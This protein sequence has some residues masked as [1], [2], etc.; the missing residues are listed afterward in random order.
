MINVSSL[1]SEQGQF[2]LISHFAGL[3]GLNYEL[4]L[5]AIKSIN[6]EIYFQEA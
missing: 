6:T 5:T 3:L 2:P 4:L 1:T